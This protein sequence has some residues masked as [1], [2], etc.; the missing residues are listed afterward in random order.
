MGTQKQNITS[1][2]EVR[3]QF[4]GPEG[5]PA[6]KRYDSGFELF[7]VGVTIAQA[8]EAQGLTEEQL[9][10]KCGITKALISKAEL[11]AENVKISVL[12]NIIE[13][14]LGGRLQLSVQ[15]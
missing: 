8:R 3:D 15:I 11:D 6:R 1:F 13:K 12:Q 9:A 7:M 2:E 5:S 4:I 14:G 10:K